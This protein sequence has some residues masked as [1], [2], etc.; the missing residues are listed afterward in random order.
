MDERVRVRNVNAWYE[1]RS[2]YLPGT[3][4]VAFRGVLGHVDRVQCYRHVAIDMGIAR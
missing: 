1:K 3:L 4:D 2:I